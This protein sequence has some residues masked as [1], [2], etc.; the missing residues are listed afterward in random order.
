MKTLTGLIVMLLVLNANAAERLPFDEVDGNILTTETQKTDGTDNAMDFIWWI[1]VEFWE[2]AL[3]GNS[4]VSPAQIAEI[5]ETLRP[6]SVLAVVQADI[7][8]FGA[9][10]FFDEDKVTQGLKVVY[11]PEQANAV[12]ISLE[13]LVDPDVTLLL[14]Q[15]SPILTAAM[16]NLGENFYF[17]PMLDTND[18]GARL[19]SPYE[20]GTLQITLTAR[21][22]VR[23]PPYEIAFPLDALHKPRLC[24]NGKPAHISWN[25]CPWS[26]KKLKQ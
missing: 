6:Y 8:S 1:P 25:Y 19:I 11:F 5:V 7:S 26:G 23:R 17:F 10:N 4:G 15:L 22:G 24:Q 16:G 21:A 13:E 12:E 3:A 9:F 20:R 18:A 14:N 2:V